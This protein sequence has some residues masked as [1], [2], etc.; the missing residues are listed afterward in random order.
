MIVGYA[1]VSTDLQQD[2]SDVSAS[3]MLSYSRPST[4]R[5]DFVTW[6]R[7]PARFVATCGS[8]VTMT[9]ASLPP[10]EQ[11]NSDTPLR[12]SVVAALAFSDGS[13]TASGLRREAARGRLVVE[14]IA[15]K[16][17]TTLANV[18]RMRELCR[19]ET[20]VPGCT[21]DGTAVAQRSGS[22][23]IA[24]AKSGQARAKMISAQLKKH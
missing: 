1:R 16:D 4:G 11:I 14:R 15:G 5:G 23:S 8:P 12:L 6:Q 21:S 17:Y 2:Q 9:P 13:M 19:V 22:S 7:N 10:R 24:A 20:R 18:E 3:T